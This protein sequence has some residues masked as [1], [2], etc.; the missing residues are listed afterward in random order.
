N[1]H[2]KDILP[3]C[4]FKKSLGSVSNLGGAQMPKKVYFCILD[5]LW[6]IGLVNKESNETRRDSCTQV[7][8]MVTQVNMEAVF[9]KEY[10][11]QKK[12]YTNLQ[13]KAMSTPLYVIT[14][15][16]LLG[17]IMLI[18][19]GETGS[20]LIALCAF[21]FIYPI[22]V[23]ALVQMTVTNVKNNPL[24]S[25]RKLKFDEEG[26]TSFLKEGK[27]VKTNWSM[28]IRVKPIKK[29]KLLYMQGRKFIYVPDS[30]F[31]ATADL[32]VFQQLLKQRNLI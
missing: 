27:E 4:S 14:G 25:K 29:A 8:S 32:E 16:I 31:E 3:Y 2:L 17:I 26:I 15:L 9:T 28:I 22:T 18:V 12:A 10:A 5:S 7:R 1:D 30:A 19:M 11:L 13:F 6:F 20:Y 24:F 23:Y 21:L